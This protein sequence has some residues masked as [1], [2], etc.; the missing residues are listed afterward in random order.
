MDEP[1]LTHVRIAENQSLFRS[2]N[3]NIEASAESMGLVREPVPFICECADATCTEI[4]RLSL[5]AYED[6]RTVPYRF[7]CA[8]GHQERAVSA[9]AAVVVDERE[10][11]VIVDKVG[12]AAE[13][14]E[15]RQV[16]EYPP[17]LTFRPREG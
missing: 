13:V 3:E 17:D 5:L 2:A 1:E 14:A 4:V 11:L 16:A 7:F 9:G 10:G 6:V 8:P 15:E 12:V